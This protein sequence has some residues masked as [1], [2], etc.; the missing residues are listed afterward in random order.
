MATGPATMAIGPAAHNAHDLPSVGALVRY[1]HACAGFPV[2][3]TWLAA[4]KAGNY[5]TWP[6]LTFANAAKYCPVVKTI[7]GHMAQSRQGTRSTKPK[8]AAKVPLPDIS[9]Q[10]PAKRSNEL[11]VIVE[12]ISKLY[13][14]DMGRSPV[15]SCSGNYYIILAYHADCNVILGKAFNS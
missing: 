1:L 10:L 12:S 7:R 4:I 8:P 9:S 6:G 13:T 15:R 2:R 5:S 11:F 14:D 3:S